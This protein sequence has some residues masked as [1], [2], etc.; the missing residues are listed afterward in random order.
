ML[1]R[2]V[3]FLTFIV[4]IGAKSVIFGGRARGHQVDL[5]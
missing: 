2:C 5:A 4:G 1:G 3:K